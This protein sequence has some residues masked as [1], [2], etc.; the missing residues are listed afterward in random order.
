MGNITSTISHRHP[1]SQILEWVWFGILQWVK[2]IVP[3]YIIR[4]D[5]VG[6]DPPWWWSE[7]RS[8]YDWFG[9]VDE[10]GLPLSCWFE[11]YFH[12]VYE[13]LGH[14]IWE[15][16][17]WAKEQGEAFVRFVV[18]YVKSG[19]YNFQDWMTWL[20]GVT[21]GVVPYFAGSLSDAAIRLYYWLPSDVR[22]NLTTWATIFENIKTSVKNWVQTTY[23]TAKQY[24]TSAYNWVIATGSTLSGWYNIAHSWLDDFRNNAATRVVGWL[25]GAWSWVVAFWN[26]PQGTITGYLGSVWS[27]LVAF[28]NN[29]LSFWFNLWGSHAEEIGQ[30]WSDP[31]GWLYDRVEDELVNRW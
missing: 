12:A 31:L 7:V 22:Q 20:E 29:A 1:L 21:G 14:W 30:F 11:N 17:Q 16:G 3:N 23:D 27:N 4:P 13:Q 19:F 25:G 18:G 8:P 2:W 15:I 5:K 28:A 10:I 9:C 24:A 26:N 6:R